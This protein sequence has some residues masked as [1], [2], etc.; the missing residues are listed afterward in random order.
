[1]CVKIEDYRRKY[2]GKV[3]RGWFF[4]LVFLFHFDDDKQDKKN[5]IKS[6]FVFVCHIWIRFGTK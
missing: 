6:K 3:N 4:F 5:I 2:K 1:M